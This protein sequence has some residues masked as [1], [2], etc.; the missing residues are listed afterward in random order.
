MQKVCSVCVHL[1]S[2]ERGVKSV[3]L[4]SHFSVI[5]NVG[6]GSV[7]TYQVSATLST[8]GVFARAEYDIGETIVTDNPCEIW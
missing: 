7:K 6:H 1:D 5:R 3:S 4:A 8:A 2:L